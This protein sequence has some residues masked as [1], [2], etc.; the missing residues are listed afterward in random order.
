[1]TA[2]EFLNQY[3]EA[4]RRARRLGAEYF[5]ELELIDA[6]RSTADIDG[7][8]HGNGI[9]KT[10]EDRAVRLADKAAEWKIAQLDAILIRQ[11]VFEAIDKVKGD[12]SDVLF[13]RYVNNKTWRGVEVAVNWSRFK[14]YQLH[15]DGL[16]QIEKIIQHSTTQT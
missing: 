8:P 9:N 2:R 15:T 14:V 3:R 4:D 1:M 12:A 10:V 5:K 7:L 16:S 13:E 6:V 11:E